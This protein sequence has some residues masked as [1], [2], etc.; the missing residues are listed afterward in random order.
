MTKQDKA[1]ETFLSGMNCAQAVFS[2]FAPDC[3]ITEDQAKMIASVYGGGIARSGRICG[4]V[5][6]AFMAIGAKYGYKDPKETGNKDKACQLTKKFIEEFTKR[7]GAII[8]NDLLGYDISDDAQNKK[9]LK[10]GC[11]PPR[12]RSLWRIRWNC[13]RNCF[14]KSKLKTQKSKIKS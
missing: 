5:N 4:A 11:I 8:C 6:G 14:S 7:N 2:A 12:A 3:G 9:G 1:K 13:W 10:Q